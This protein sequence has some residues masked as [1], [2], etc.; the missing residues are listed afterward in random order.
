[1]SGNKKLIGGKVLMQCVLACAATDVNKTFAISVLNVQSCTHDYSLKQD[2]LYSV[3]GK[4]LQ[5]TRWQVMEEADRLFIWVTLAGLIIRWGVLRNTST[6]LK[7]LRWI[8]MLG[9]NHMLGQGEQRYDYSE[10]VTVGSTRLSKGEGAW[11][12]HIS[13]AQLN[14]PHLPCLALIKSCV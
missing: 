1:M 10:C 8:W 12:P 14:C 5:T 13:G 9:L 11:P 6:A 3:P 4:T 2:N 7:C